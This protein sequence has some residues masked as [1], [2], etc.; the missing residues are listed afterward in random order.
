M[1]KIQL[2]PQLEVSRIIHGHWRLL[3]WGLSDKELTNFIEKLMAHGVTTFDH[4]DIYGDYACEEVFGKAL[5]LNR[6]LREDMQIITKCGI[7]LMSDKYPDRKVKSYDYSYTH[8]VNS[9]EQSLKKLNTDYIDLLLLHRPS[10]L[11]DPSE[12]AK[13][14]G[15]LKQSGK[16][17]YFGVS[18]FNP[19]QFEMLQ[20][21]LDEKLLTNQVEISPL[22]IAAF[23]D[24]TVEGALK[25]RIKPMAWSPLAGGKL[26][27]PANVHEAEVQKTIVSI[28]EEMGAKGIDQV[29]YSW[30]LK[31]PA[32][33]LP[34]VGSGKIERLQN[35]VEAPSL[36]MTDE[37][38]YRIF[39]AAKGEELP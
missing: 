11:F 28:A 24:G 14:F 13:A 33:I 10:P 12:V 17:R 19:S 22:N 21:Y 30:L 20:S 32:G 4:A 35:A 15:D 29:V 2:A 31:H 39:I 9:A 6:G 34:I 1:D 3:D 25:H 36:K 8:I 16:V 18:N 5:K 38:W 7:K 26:F 27:N 37:Q 23:E